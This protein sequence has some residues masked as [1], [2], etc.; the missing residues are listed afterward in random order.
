MDIMINSTRSLRLWLNRVAV[1]MRSAGLM[2]SLVFTA[3]AIT[4]C[5][6]SDDASSP[7]APPDTPAPSQPK[8]DSPVILSGSLSGEDEVT[9]AGSQ[10]ALQEY[11]DAEHG[12]TT[13]YVW[14]YKDKA[15]ATT[16]VMQ[17]YVVNYLSGSSGSSV[18]NSRGWEY[19]NQGSGVEQ[20]V[21]YWDFQAS[22]YRF[23]GYT[24]SGVLPS[25]ASGNVSFEITVDATASEDANTPLFSKMWYKTGSQIAANVQPVTL[26]FIRPIARVRFMF[27]F[28]D[29][30][31]FT[32]EQLSDI[33]F[34]RTDGNNSAKGG[35]VT[36]T[37]PLAGTAETWS[38]EA[39]VFYENTDFDIDYYETPSPPVS[40]ANSLP[41]TYPNSPEHWYY[42]L[43]IDGQGSYT[44]SVTVGGGEPRT[45]IVPAEYMTWNP[46]YD[47]T[48]IFK[49][50]E[51]G[52][53][54][55]DNVQ[56]AVNTWNVRASVEH[57]VYNW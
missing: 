42:V 14:S 37:Y 45:I 35:K 19:V 30:I 29:G 34:H 49:I 9:R 17:N 6:G 53:V 31:A 54:S 5:G 26:E 55:L 13:F 39:T 4:A 18:T 41:N 56:V 32:R 12:H 22:A 33:K 47:Y 27:T 44:L 40:P 36:I 28:V 3:T 8:A 38:S 21:K 52:G 51:G 20:S 7:S 16:T 43:P 10:T 57:P 24:G 25:S 2:L 1:R 48:Y 46:G 15:S 23:F 50:T 11:P